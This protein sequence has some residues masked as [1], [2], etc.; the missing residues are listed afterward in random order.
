MNIIVCVKQVP[1][2]S[3]V[4]IDPQTNNLVREG[5]PGILNPYDENAMEAALQLRDEHGGSV[6]A[7]SMGPMQAAEAL[8]YCLQMGAD[9]ALLLSDRAVGG[10]DTLA[11]GYALSR[12]AAS[13]PFDLILCGNEAIDG[14]TGQVGPIIAGNLGIAQFTYARGVSFEGGLLRVERDAGRNMEYYEAKL[15]AVVCVLKDSNKPRKRTETDKEPEILTAAD[16]ALA[17]EKI[18]NDGSPT[19]VVKIEMSDARAKSYVEIDDSLPAEERIRM[20]LNGGIAKKEKIDLWRGDADT[21]A[22]RLMELPE[23]NRFLSAL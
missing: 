20:I 13:Q 2:T 17:P 1:D 11:T 10:S 15:P 5:V 4:K 16:L 21:L 22:G 14:C 7:I 12:L 3:E 23:L 6:T 18:G 19:K 9:K 8:R